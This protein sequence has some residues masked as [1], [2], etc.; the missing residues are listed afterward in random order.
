[1][2]GLVLEGGGAKGAFQAGAIKAFNK[3][4]IHF[5]G[6]VGTSI[7]SINA[8]LYVAKDS[9][10]MD[11]LWYQ[12]NKKDILNIEIS[13]KEQSL[14]DD[15]KLKYDNFIKI[16]KNKGIDIKHIRELLNKYLDEDKVRK[17]GIDFGLVTYNLT[18]FKP[19]EIFLKD[20]PYGKLND[21][22]IAS[23]Y[24]PCFKYEK[25]IDDKFYID[26]GIYYNCPIDMLVKKGYDEIYVV[27][28]WMGKR[29]RYTKNTNTKIH[30]I[31]PSKSVGSIMDF[32]PNS[33]SD[34]VNY[35]YYETLKYLDNLD[36]KK[37]YFKNYNEKYYSK[38]FTKEKM[39]MMR[40]KYRKQLA[41]SDKTFILNIL[42]EICDEYN[43]NRFKVYNIPFLITKL[44]Y[45]M[46]LHRDSKY[47]DFIKKIEINF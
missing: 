47:Y 4:G 29:I 15:I 42:E 5:D 33:N 31:S 34:K 2:R 18:D 27:K 26:G 12:L 39:K 46:V 3:K 24:L 37:Y 1:M 22:L 7:G 9:A 35:G 8:A 32:D 21:Y 43:I 40:K 44:K 25:I 14:I 36:G 13:K 17:S 45:L 38:L 16:L 41:K 10:N 28:V 20:I 19:V 11:R 30:L 23:S 6:V